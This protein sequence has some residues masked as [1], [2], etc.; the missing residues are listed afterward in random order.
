M[1]GTL[2]TGRC[3]K[4][5]TRSLKDFPPVWTLY[6]TWILTLSKRSLYTSTMKQSCHMLLSLSPSPASVWTRGHQIMF[7][8]CI[9]VHPIPAPGLRK[10]KHD[11]TWTHWLILI[12]GWS[13]VFGLSIAFTC[14]IYRIIWCA[15]VALLPSTVALRTFKNETMAQC[16]TDCVVLAGTVKPGLNYSCVGTEK[17]W[18]KGNWHDYYESC[19]WNFMS[20]RQKKLTLEA[21]WETGVPV[22]GWLGRLKTPL[23]SQNFGVLLLLV[24]SVKEL[25]MFF[26]VYQEA[27]TRQ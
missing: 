6:Q 24:W 4:A 2:R 1:S 23:V 7:E 8:K 19:L 22:S 26:T 11:E 14:Y 17:H 20:R 10:M 25:G 27:W 3:S 15:N 9:A 5:E 12:E 18:P 13:M 21:W 16:R